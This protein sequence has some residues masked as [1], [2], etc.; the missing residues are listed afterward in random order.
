MTTSASLTDA[1]V[2]GDL[3][4]RY[5]EVRAFTERL[6]EPLSPEDQTIQSMPDVSPTKWHRA[7]TTW[8]FETFLLGA[9]QSGYTPFD[10][11]YAFL[12]NSYYEAVGPRHARVERGLLS[13]P[14]CEEIAE[15]RA[16]VDQAMRRFLAGDLAADVAWL[17]EL[18]L[19]HEQQH[20]ELLLMDI[21]HVLGTNPTRP[22]YRPAE[23]PPLRVTDPPGWVEH[24]GG[25]VTI[26]HGGDGFAFDNEGPVHEVLLRPFALSSRLV[27][28]GEWLEFMEDG[29]YE[30]PEL[31]M[32]DGWATIRREGWDAPAYW[33]RAG[34]DGSDGDDNDDNDDDVQGRPASG[35]DEWEIHTL[36]GVFPIEPNE[37]VCH[38][39]WYEA[40]AFARWAGCRLPSEVE[41]E[42]VAT[43]RLGGAGVAGLDTAKLESGLGLHPRPP[44]TLTS[45]DTAAD[46]QWTGAVWQW[47][48]SNYGPYPGFEP[49]AG[50]VGEY[51]GKFMVNQQTLRGG[52]C[53]TP[54]GH[55]RKTYR[56]F[57][58]PSARWPFCGLRLAV[59]R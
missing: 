13:R 7:H 51:N 11:D 5:E 33:R 31:W 46:E 18:G 45:G 27:S 35:S 44:G 32:S 53:I 47:T 52:A 48:A 14:G 17:V 10:P 28:C 42:A 29:G 6:A 34:D 25:T 40:D 2:A 49:A 58:Y 8:F 9:H 30:R 56:N 20:Q 21:K 55:T 24:P 3:L 59:D 43:A 22:A 16:S 15:Y 4:E 50:A 26:G 1:A 39:S 41:W 54:A 37:P 38:V 23:R 57:F 36:T 12:F 19:H